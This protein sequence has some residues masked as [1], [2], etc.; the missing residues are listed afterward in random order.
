MPKLKRKPKRH[1]P[2][3][4][5][6]QPLGLPGWAQNQIQMDNYKRKGIIP[7]LQAEDK[8]LAESE[9]LLNEI[10]GQIFKLRD[11]LEKIPSTD[12]FQPVEYS[13]QVLQQDIQNIHLYLK[14]LQTRIDIITGKI[15]K[16]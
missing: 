15:R 3:N 16:P 12:V 10:S 2:K 1:N 7:S 5:W 4:W 9:K 8:A 14:G 11:S 6:E 13:M